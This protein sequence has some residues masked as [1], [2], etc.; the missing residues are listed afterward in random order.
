M[1]GEVEIILAG[2]LGEDS[3]AGRDGAAEGNRYAAPEGVGQMDVIDPSC[4]MACRNENLDVG[5]TGDG[6]ASKG[7]TLGSPGGGSLRAG[8]PTLNPRSGLI[9]LQDEDRQC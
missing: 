7:Q 6:A 1:S 2:G 5:L 9:L 4:A 8:H 3:A